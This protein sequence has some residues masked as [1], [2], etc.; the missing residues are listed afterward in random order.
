MITTYEQNG[1][2]MIVISGDKSNL[3]AKALQSLLGQIVGRGRA[4]TT[5]G[6]KPIEVVVDNTGTEGAHHVPVD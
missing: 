2:T 4:K 1:R 6:G 5:I 3:E